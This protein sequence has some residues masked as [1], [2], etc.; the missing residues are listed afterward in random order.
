MSFAYSRRTAASVIAS[1]SSVQCLEPQWS[2]TPS[3][4][5]TLQETYPLSVCCRNAIWRKYR[6]TW[7]LWQKSQWCWLLCSDMG[8]SRFE[9]SLRLRSA[10]ACPDA[11]WSPVKTPFVQLSKR[12]YGF[13]ERKDGFNWVSRDKER[14]STGRSYGS[15][16]AMP[17]PPAANHCRDRHGDS[18]VTAATHSWTHCHST[19]IFAAFA[20]SAHFFVSAARNAAK[21]CADPTFAST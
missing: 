21:S 12:K 1:A 17:I 14:V 19:L 20:T 10:S 5:V 4:M 13:V 18:G 9:V 16:G 8:R 2:Q 11:H 6:E 15:R 3:G 7:P